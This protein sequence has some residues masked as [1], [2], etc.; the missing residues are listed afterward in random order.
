MQIDTDILITW[1][2]VY[3]KFY[4]HENVFE[5]GAH[6]KYYHQIVDG[7]VKMYNT[8]EEGKEFIQGMFKSGESFGEPPLFIN[9]IYPSSAITCHE[10]VIIRLH[11]DSFFKLLAEYPKIQESFNYLFAKRIYSKAITSREIVNNNP[12][13]RII[14]FLDSFKKSEN[15]DQSK[16]A[17]LI[18]YTRQEI[19]N[20]TGLRVETVIRTLIKMDECGK[21]SIQNRKVYY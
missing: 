20:F 9:E 19:A 16:T 11:K 12:E 7:D 13:H 15:L 1:G 17:I 18:P 21:V 4:K 14:A 2:A 8:N 5:E 10:S 3:K 6:P